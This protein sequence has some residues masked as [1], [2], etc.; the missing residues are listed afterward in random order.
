[1]ADP[2]L[3]A[4]F[5]ENAGERR[6]D[7]VPWWCGSRQW[8]PPG[9]PGAMSGPP[10]QTSPGGGSACQSGHGAARTEHSAADARTW[11][12]YWWAERG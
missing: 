12:V 3:M 1:M 5:P 2:H 8:D 9:P 4:G 10:Q 11:G 7:P 6:R